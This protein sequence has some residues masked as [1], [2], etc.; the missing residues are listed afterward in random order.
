MPGPRE[1]FWNWQKNVDTFLAILAGKITEA[2]SKMNK[3]T[4]DSRPYG[5]RPQSK[6]DTGAFVS[7]PLV[8]DG[9]NK[10]AQGSV[11]FSDIARDK[12]PEDAVAIKRYNGAQADWCSWAS[13]SKTDTTNHHWQWNYGQNNYVEEVCNLIEEA[14]P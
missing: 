9:Q 8:Y 13:S 4:P 3:L 6:F 11:R 1:V 2:E 5:Q 12:R 14:Q 10:G 7:I